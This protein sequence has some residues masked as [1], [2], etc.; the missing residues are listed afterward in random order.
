MT[1]EIET[2]PWLVEVPSGNP[3]PDFPED[4]YR[5]IECGAEVTFNEYGSWT[6]AAGHEHVT[7]DDPRRDSYDAEMAW[8]ERNE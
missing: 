2:C 6:C 8:N 4:L 1:D 3:E 7:Y 5:V